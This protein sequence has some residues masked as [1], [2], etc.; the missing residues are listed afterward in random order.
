MQ[1]MMDETPMEFIGIEETKGLVLFCAKLA[2]AIDSSLEDGKIGFTDIGNLWAP[3]T[4]VKEAFEGIKLVPSELLDLSEEEE[5]ELVDAIKTELDI[6]NDK[7]E[8][9]AEEAIRM[10]F[11]I[12]QFITTL[13]GMKK[14]EE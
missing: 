9:I 6:S 13:R 8:L 12:A 4:K 5:A 14:V 11:S 2:N 7:A 3:I 10:A 1:E